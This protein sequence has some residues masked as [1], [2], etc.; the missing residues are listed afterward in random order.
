MTDLVV[1]ESDAERHARR[2][3]L[4]REYERLEKLERRARRRK[5]YPWIGFVLAQSFVAFMTFAML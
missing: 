4:F 2:V 1:Y 5:V 3:K